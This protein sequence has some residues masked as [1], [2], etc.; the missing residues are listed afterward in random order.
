M[1]KIKKINSYL[2]DQK[3]DATYSKISGKLRLIMRN[4]KLQLQAE[5]AIYSYDDLYSVFAKG[6]KQVKIEKQVLKNVLILGFGMASVPLILEKHYKKNANYIGVEIDA[7][8]A[9][10]NTKY[11]NVAL[12]QKCKIE[13]ADAYTYI[14]ALEKEIKFDL[15]VVDIFIGSRTPEKFKEE[16]FLEKIKTHLNKNGRLLYNV[17]V[18][19][20]DL[21]EEANWFFENEF[22]H[23]FQKPKKHKVLENYLLEGWAN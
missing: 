22:S 1:L 16:K 7:L 10:W 12:M 5:D 15:I 18:H 19:K 21:K 8:I 3:I 11:S 17:L 13:I 9:E 2:F 14:F 4:G 6:F 23:V 20:S